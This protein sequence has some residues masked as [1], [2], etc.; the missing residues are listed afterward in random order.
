[1]SVL[2]TTRGQLEAL[3]R[4]PET[5]NIFSQKVN[6]CSFDVLANIMLFADGIRERMWDTYLFDASGNPK[7]VEVTRDATIENWMACCADRFIKL[8]KTVQTRT[9]TGLTRSATDPTCPPDTR[10]GSTGGRCAGILLAHLGISQMSERDQ[11]KEDEG[12]KALNDAFRSL[13]LDADAQII[14]TLDE[15]D[16]TSYNPF[17]GSVPTTPVKRYEV[18]RGKRLVAIQY[19]LGIDRAGHVAV[20]VKVNGVWYFMDNEIG[21]SIPTTFSDEDV[22]EPSSLSYTTDGAGA[23][24]ITKNGKEAVGYG[25][26]MKWTGTMK[27]H[28]QVLNPRVYVSVATA[29]G[30]RK[31]STFRRRRFSAP[32]R[33]ATSSSGRSR[34]HTRR[35]KASRS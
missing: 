18:P 35:R 34:G 30:K 20:F 6:I 26:S 2:S 7:P 23:Y 25:P 27:E 5:F 21:V 33:K 29:G 8:S 19:A 10:E 3:Y 13:K 4:S 15:D 11:L 31:R 28:N 9:A 32:T 12:M 14:D 24:T 17:F 16:D 22:S 1:M